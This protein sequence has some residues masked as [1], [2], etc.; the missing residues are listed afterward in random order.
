MTDGLFR[1]ADFAAFGQMQARIGIP[2]EGGEVAA[3]DLDPDPV[4]DFEGPRGRPAVDVVCVY[5]SGL[6]QVLMVQTVTEAGANDAI[7]NIP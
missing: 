6:K 7:A 3:A 1:L 2:V 4:T 5:F